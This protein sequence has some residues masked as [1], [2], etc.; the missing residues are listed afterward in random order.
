[1]DAFGLPKTTEDEKK[2]RKAVIRTATINA[3]QVPLKVMQLAMQSME[4]LKAMAEKG[5]PNS[6]SDAG[7]GV[8]CARTA[9]RGA[10]LNVR[11]NAPGLDDKEK[12]ADLLAEAAE[13]AHKA[14]IAEEEI[15]RIVESKIT[16]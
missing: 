7:V 11:I 1:M 3:M 14:E 4:V 16:G 6:V 2:Y 5:N 12:A 9:V 10:W 15:L 8:L 13:I